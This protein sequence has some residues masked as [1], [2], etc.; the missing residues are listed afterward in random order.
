MNMMMII[1]QIPSTR[2]RHGHAR[3][4]GAGR[5]RAVRA[6]HMPHHAISIRLHAHGR[7]SRHTRVSGAEQLNTCLACREVQTG[8]RFH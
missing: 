5:I 4:N 7:R 3:I 6:A 1:P 2:R 8:T